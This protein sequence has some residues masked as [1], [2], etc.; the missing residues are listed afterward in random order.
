MNTRF[1]VVKKDGQVPTYEPCVYYPHC[2]CEF[3]LII[4][5]NIHKIKKEVK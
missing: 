1:K 5:K 3:H 4:E 2:D